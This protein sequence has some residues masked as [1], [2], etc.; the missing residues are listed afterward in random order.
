MIGGI[1]GDIVGSRSEG[2][3][4]P[5]PGFELFHPSCRFTDDTVC[6]VAVAA[7][8]MEGS[9]F[10][11]TLKDF[12]RRHPRRGYGG[13]FLDWAFSERV[14]GYGSWGNGA[15]MRVAAVGWLAVDGADVDRLAA[16]QAEVSH[17]HPDAVAAAQAVARS[18]LAFRSGVRV[19]AVR[20]ATGAASATT[21]APRPPWPAEASMCLPPARRRPPWRRHSRRPTG[22]MP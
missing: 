14:E 3:P 21:C 4:A 1:A 2:G 20:E 22:R 7:A 18:I 12:V 8:I 13:M 11:A 10:A 17:G 9:D 6:T 15:P 19:E 16:A 5:P